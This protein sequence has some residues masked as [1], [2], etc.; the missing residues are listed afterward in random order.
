MMARGKKGRGKNTQTPTRVTRADNVHKVAEALLTMPDLATANNSLFDERSSSDVGSSE[1]DDEADDEEFEK[2]EQL[3]KERLEIIKDRKR[4]KRISHYSDNNSITNKVMRS[5]PQLPDNG[6]YR[7]VAQ[8]NLN[9]GGE[10]NHM[11]RMSS[12]TTAGISCDECLLSM[13]H[14]VK[15]RVQW[16]S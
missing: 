15:D 10:S 1:D 12:I 14:F 4:N 6:S 2:Q 13:Y 3:L 9:T 7:R 8:I 5:N 16:T 11:D